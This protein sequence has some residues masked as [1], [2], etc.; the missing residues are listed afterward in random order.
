M[1]KP[2]GRRPKKG[3]TLVAFTSRL[4]PATVDRIYA[5]AKER[6]LAPQELVRE[7]FERGLPYTFLPDS[8]RVM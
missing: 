8:G 7:I 3:V 5:V 1:A 6:R 4:P 2:P